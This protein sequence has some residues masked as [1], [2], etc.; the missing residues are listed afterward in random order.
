MAKHGSIGEFRQE[1]EEWSAYAERLEYYFAANDVAAGDKKRAILQSVCG[2]STYVLIRS[3]VASQKP[4][5]FSFEDLVEK[6]NKY[7]PQPTTISGGPALQVQLAD[8]AVGRNGGCL[9]SGAEEV[10]RVL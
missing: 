7:I 1:V 4:T 6:V 5:E 2:P 3:L 8:A 9:R 10:V